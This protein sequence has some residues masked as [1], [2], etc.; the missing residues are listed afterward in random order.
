MRQ[1]CE[2]SCDFRRG[3]EQAF[4]DVALG[5]DGRIPPLPPSPYWKECARSPCGHERVQEWYAGYAAGANE[6]VACRGQS[7]YVYSAGVPDCDRRVTSSE[8]R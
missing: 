8:C 1:N 3:Y 7:N 2:I 6:A 4:E 5:A